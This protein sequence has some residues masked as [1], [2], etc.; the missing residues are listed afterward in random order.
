ML[1]EL[2]FTGFATKGVTMVERPSI[3]SLFVPVALGLWTSV[4][5]QFKRSTWS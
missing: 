3:F 5:E 4:A 2:A 1:S